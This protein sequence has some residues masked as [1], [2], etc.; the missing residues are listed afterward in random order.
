[1]GRFFYKRQPERIQRGV[2]F[3]SRVQAG[4]D[5]C[6]M[7]KR[8]L[9]DN[10]WTIHK[11]NG[12]DQGDILAEFHG[13]FILIETKELYDS[14]ITTGGLHI[15]KYRKRW[16]RL[17]IMSLLNAYDLHR[18]DKAILVTTA[19]INGRFQDAY[20][21]GGGG[22]SCPQIELLQYPYFKDWIHAFTGLIDTGKIKPQSRTGPLGGNQGEP[23]VTGT[24]L[25]ICRNSS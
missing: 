2:M 19:T 6:E 18:P 16:G 21:L 8:I 5:F 7:I 13:Y 4:Q 1:M 22:Q 17:D 24:Y 15:F 11:T 20:L 14:N 12:K 25:P 10:G 9:I 23:Q 3:Q